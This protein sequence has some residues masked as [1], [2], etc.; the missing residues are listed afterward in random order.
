M[1]VLAFIVRVINVFNR[2]VGNVFAWLSLAIVLVCFA[3]VVQRYALSTTR[4]W[5]QDLYVWLNGAMFTAVAGFALL[6]NDHVRVDIFYRPATV[7]RKALVDLIG[8]IFFLM[9]FAWVV[10]AYGWNFVARSWRIFEG[11]AN[12]G[13][14]PGLFI[15]KSFILFFAFVIAI[16]GLSMA[17]RSILVLTRNEHL[18]PAEYR[19]EN[20]QETH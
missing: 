13:G 18:L 12:I 7:E 17:L 10:Y 8:V 16:Q 5:M 3:V 15:L 19:Y 4:L 9:P 14:M 6:R 20:Q 2:L 11:S 1:S